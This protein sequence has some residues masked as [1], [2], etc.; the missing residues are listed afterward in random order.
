MT[1]IIVASL[2]AVASF[3]L[4]LLLGDHLAKRSKRRVVW[5]NLYESGTRES[6]QEAF[7]YDSKEHADKDHMEAEL[8]YPN[9][10]VYRVGG[11]AYRL[12]VDA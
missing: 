8:N 11:R 4:G 1:T 2:A 12:E 9:P 10:A 6:D 3:G 5:L 7:W